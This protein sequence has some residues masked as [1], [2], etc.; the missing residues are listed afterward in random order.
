MLV[1][2]RVKEVLELIDKY[3]FHEIRVLGDHHRYTDGKGHYVTVPYSRIKDTLPP[4]PTL[5]YC[6]KWGLNSPVCGTNRHPW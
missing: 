2:H 4:R 5:Q 3:G 6:D 1:Q